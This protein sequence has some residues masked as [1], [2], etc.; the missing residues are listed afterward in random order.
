MNPQLQ[1]TCPPGDRDAALI[2][3]AGIPFRDN[4]FQPRGIAAGDLP[5][6]LLEVWHASFSRLGAFEPGEWF[7]TFVVMDPG[8]RVTVACAPKSVAVKEPILC[9]TVSRAYEDG[10]PCDPLSFVLS[11]AASLHFFEVLTSPAFWADRGIE[12]IQQGYRHFQ[13]NN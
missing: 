12:P 13:F 4:L 6:D 11:D 5:P 2:V 10:S 9:C 7:A 3:A 8:E 1:I